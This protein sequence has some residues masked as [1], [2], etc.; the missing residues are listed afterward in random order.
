MKPEQIEKIEVHTYK[1]AVGSHDHSRILGISSAKLSTPFGVALAIVK[2]RAGFAD[3][4]EDNLNADEIINLTRKVSV[5]EDVDFT[6]R[7]PAVRGAKVTV[8]LTEGGV[9]EACSL[10]PKG[11][12]ENPLSNQELED[13]FRGLAMYGGLTSKACDNE[14]AEIRKPVPVPIWFDGLKLVPL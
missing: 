13:K 7:S 14:I 9:F 10:Y 1:L 8:Y 12:P 4:N 2:G 3:Y 11:E 5:I 6:R